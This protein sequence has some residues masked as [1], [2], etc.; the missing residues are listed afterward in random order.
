VPSADGTLTGSPLPEAAALP[1]SIDEVERA[2]ALAEEARDLDGLV[3]RLDDVAA[4][5]R[6]A[7][8]LCH[9]LIGRPLRLGEFAL[10]IGLSLFQSHK[11]DGCVL[12]LAFGRVVIGPRRFPRRFRFAPRLFQFRL[13]RNR[14]GGS[15]RNGRPA[16]RPSQAA[17]NADPPATSAACHGA[18][19]AMREAI[20][21]MAP[22]NAASGRAQPSRF[23]R[24]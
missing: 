3:A 8:R 9:C 10:Y 11:R 24:S 1:A 16:A 15:Q 2:L 20:Q 22:L 5:R 6:E 21:S 19:A 13:A 18:T 4:L 23:A 7:L 12:L 14:G 17:P